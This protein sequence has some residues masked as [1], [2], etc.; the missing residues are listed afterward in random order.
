MK[1]HPK[2][3]VRKI[4]QLLK[5]TLVEKNFVEVF[6]SHWAKPNGEK[7]SEFE[8]SPTAPIGPNDQGQVR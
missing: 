8:Y 7:S 4:T 6:F 5:I 3:S 2:T 1:T